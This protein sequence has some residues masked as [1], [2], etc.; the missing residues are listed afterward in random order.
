M[1]KPE[2][3]RNGSDFGTLI[4]LNSKPALITLHPKRLSFFVDCGYEI[5]VKPPIEREKYVLY[6]VLRAEK[7]E[8]DSFEIRG[9]S[10]RLVEGRWV[11]RGGWGSP[12]LITSIAPHPYEDDEG[13]GSSIYV[14]TISAEKPIIYVCS[15]LD[16]PNLLVPKENVILV[17]V[18]KVQYY[19]NLLRELEA[20]KQ[21]LEKKRQELESS[22]WEEYK[23]AVD[24]LIKYGG[25]LIC[26]GKCAVVYRDGDVECYSPNPN[27]NT[28]ELA[29]FVKT[30]VKYFR[31]EV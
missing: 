31:G 13:D 24:D 14:T 20:K 16:N 29:C 25:I 26:E 28:I 10:L 30:A 9:S 5:L 23:A 17:D 7:V 21:E 2:P 18:G 22:E 6:E 1:F 3:Y 8:D 4:S 11:F 15:L 19:N 12:P 27:I